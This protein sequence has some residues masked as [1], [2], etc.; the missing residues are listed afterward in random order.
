M[1]NFIRYIS[2]GIA[3]EASP[4]DQIHGGFEVLLYN[5][6][7][8]AAR[9]QMTIYFEDRPP[10]TLSE[11]IS[12]DPFCSFLQV[13]SNTDPEVI[14]N[15]GVWG[16]KYESDVPL[17]PILISASGDW[18]KESPSSVFSGGV[19]HLLGTGLFKEW[20]FPHGIYKPAAPVA[21]LN[22]ALPISEQFSEMELYCILNPGPEPAEVVLEIHFPDGHY[23]TCREKASAQ[24]L[25]VWSNLGKAAP[26][27]LYAMKITSSQP[28][29]VS[30]L[31][32]VFDAREGMRSAAVRAGI[33]GIPVPEKG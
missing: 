30:A 26:N 21:K 33:P 31:R 1:M 16:A 32:C 28:V 15:S 7:R 19:T 5:P 9:V 4:L 27:T 10:H 6:S 22:R 14:Q 23:E 12:I 13:T 18:Q 29:A 11:A 20:H 25:L 3:R 24:R 17:V 2:A 8:T